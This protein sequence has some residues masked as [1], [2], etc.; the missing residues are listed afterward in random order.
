MKLNAKT[1]RD[2]ALGYPEVRED[3]PWG[4]SAFKVKDKTFVFLGDRE[5]VV[6]FSVKLPHSRD[7]ALSFDGTEPTHYGLGK[8]GWVTI[9]VGKETRIPPDVLRAWIDESFRAIAPKKLVA[10][11]PP[12][13]GAKK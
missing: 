9:T 5:G 6:S 8:S 13:G 4:E 12:A 10:T 11:L 3:H 1:I 7:F 2:I